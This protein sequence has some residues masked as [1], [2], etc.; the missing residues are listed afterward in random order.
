MSH[1]SVTPP[2]A[3]PDIFEQQ[4]DPRPEATNHHYDPTARIVTIRDILDGKFEKTLPP[5]VKKTNSGNE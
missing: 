3:G 1:S 5:M 4:M 2:L